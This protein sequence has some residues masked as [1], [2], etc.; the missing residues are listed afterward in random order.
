MKSVISATILCFAIGTGGALA[1]V[2]AAPAA[3]PVAAPAEAATPA[4]TN[5]AKP[6]LSPDEKKKISQECSAQANEKSLHGKD[7]RTFR[8]GC[9][10][11]GGLA[12]ARAQ[13]GDNG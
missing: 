12:A 8:A 4:T 2:P 9:I 10:K 11:R 5:T 7:R 3:A 13:P 6:K 1:Q